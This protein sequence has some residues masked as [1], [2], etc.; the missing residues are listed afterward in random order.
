RVHLVLPM[1]WRGAG[2]HLVFLLAMLTAL[3]VLLVVPDP[4]LAGLLWAAVV[5][6]G[7]GVSWATARL[8]HVVGGL[9]FVAFTGLLI[10]PA[11]VFGWPLQ[12]PEA[13]LL[14]GMFT[15]VQMINR[16]GS[17]LIVG[18]GFSALAFIGM[19]S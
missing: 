11:A 6:L 16:R 4:G 7:V 14:A 8:G 18:V 19:F 15:V 9:G 2:R 12:I 17:E 10:W 13:L 3:S 1:V 5:A